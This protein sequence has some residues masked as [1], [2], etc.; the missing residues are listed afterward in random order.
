[1][2]VQG[3][4]QYSEFAY[5][6]AVLWAIT[7]LTSSPLYVSGASMCSILPGLLLS[8]IAGTL[9][10]RFDRRWVIV[11]ANAARAAVAAA[12]AVLYLAGLVS[13]WMLL[14][15]TLLMSFLARLYAPA[16]L[17]LLP[18]TISRQD[19]QRANSTSSLMLNL[20]YAA[21]MYLCALA[22]ERLGWPVGAGI[23][24]VL[25]AVTCPLAAGIPAGAG[26]AGGAGATGPGKTPRRRHMLSDIKSALALV[27]GQRRIQLYLMLTVCGSVFLGTTTL[28]PVYIK[29]GLGKTMLQYGIVEGTSVAGVLVATLLLTRI[30]V[31]RAD[32]ILPCC[33]ATMALCMFWLAGSTTVHSLVLARI[34]LAF[35]LGCFNVLYT[36]EFHRLL[37]ADYRGRVFSL[38]YVVSTV[39]YLISTGLAGLAAEYAPIWTVWVAA[40]G[41]GLVV[42]GVG[43]LLLRQKPGALA[44]LPQTPGQ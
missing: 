16:Y 19:L 12:L 34:T 43:L 14:A 15:V 33:T 39:P 6:M 31:R 18:A 21:G 7:S 32:L 26:G 30:Q 29:T 35:F 42:E 25:F 10:D 4:S 22:T 36:T 40:G 37:P 13:L 2:A 3:F 24:A 8:L 20:A 41:L 11:F 17:A 44:N 5:M 27:A 9:V 38:G 23:V 1:M 28:L